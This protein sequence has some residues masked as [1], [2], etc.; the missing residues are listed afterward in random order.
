VLF[1]LL[2]LEGLG[3]PGRESRVV[4]PVVED[5]K[6]LLEKDNARGGLECVRNNTYRAL[7]GCGWL[8]AARAPKAGG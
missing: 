5:G 2:S 1:N 4:V 6:V 7:R 3:L 8:P